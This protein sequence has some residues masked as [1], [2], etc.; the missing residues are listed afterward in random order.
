MKKDTYYFSHDYNAR[1]D[2]KMVK[3]RLKLKMEGLGI[4]WALVEMMYEEGGQISFE[5]IPVIETELRIKKGLINQVI[6]DYELFEN[7]GKIFWSNSVKRR[8]DKRLEKTEK[9]KA[10]ASHRWQ[11]A[12][13]MRTQTDGNA[14]KERKGKENK[15]KEIKVNI[16]TGDKSP[17]KNY[18]EFSQD[19]FITELEKFKEKY[20]KEL[21]NNFYKYWKETS[22]GGKMRFQ[23][24]KTWETELRLENWERNNKQILNGTHKQSINGS[25]TEK[26]GTSAARI[27]AARNW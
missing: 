12:N 22:P 5:E 2:R 23:L 24:E 11:N 18:K 14:I 15:G 20:P 3:L 26:L 7:D 16:N 19:D 17:K 10:S 1:N 21:L 6:S 4:Y 8:L 13:A 25:N 9:A 27:K